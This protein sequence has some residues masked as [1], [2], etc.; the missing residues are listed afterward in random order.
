MN[1]NKH[2]DDILNF[3]SDG[4]RTHAP[5]ETGALNQRL[6]PLGHATLI[7]QSR[8]SILYVYWLYKLLQINHCKF[9]SIN[10]FLCTKTDNERRRL[11]WFKRGMQVSTAPDKRGEKIYIWKNGTE[12]M[13]YRSKI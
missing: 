3:G 6:G 9:P 7:I 13:T 4:I 12:K 10:G 1:I 5:E 11:I 8:A 2:E